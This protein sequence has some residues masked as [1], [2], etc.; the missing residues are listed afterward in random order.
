LAAKARSNRAEMQTPVQ[1]RPGK[2]NMINSTEDISKLGLLVVIASFGNKQ[3]KYLK[4]VIAMYKSMAMSV[5]IIVTSNIPKDLGEGVRV[6]VG[7]PSK[8]PWSLPFAHKAILAENVDRYDLF[9][10][11]E[12]DILVTEANIR[13]FLRSTQLLS[14]NEIAGHLRYEQAPSGEI[15]MPDVLGHFHWKPESVR[16]QNG[17][18]VAE[19]TNEHAGFYLLTQR[20][21]KRAISS[22][23]F[24][25]APYTGRYGMLET[26]ATD[27][28][29]NCGFRKVICISQL[30]DFLVHH[31]SNRYAGKVGIPRNIFDQQIQALMKIR[32]GTHPTGSLCELA[33]QLPQLWWSKD[34]YERPQVE[35][36]QLVPEKAKNILSLGCGWGATEAELKRAG[37]KVTALPVDSI[38]GAVAAQ[39]G[40]EVIYGTLKD[41]LKQLAGRKFDCVIMTDLLHLMP[42]QGEILKTCF[43]LL[44]EGGTLLISG[45]NFGRMPI[46]AKRIAGLGDYK[47]LRSF[48]Q[49]GIN[50]SGPRTIAKLARNAGL[51]VSPVEWINHALPGRKFADVR[52]KLGSLTAKNWILKATRQAGTEVH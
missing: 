13:A 19:F 48:K 2:K 26:A 44:Q 41:G 7:L 1:R 30:D 23:G 47:N 14:E 32:S 28:F 10:Y 17:L 29:T 46:F 24:L 3:L 38:L 6:V 18:T 37:T 27:P 21:L 35:L 39:R 22:G 43:E 50:I 8:N 25:R 45:T 12:D 20:Q 16:E 4:Q 42:D 34:Y 49:S 5:D 33:T 11:T 31:M 40:I 51:Y 9:I 52:M 15:W 36:M